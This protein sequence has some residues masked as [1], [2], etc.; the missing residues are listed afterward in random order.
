ML[1]TLRTDKQKEWVFIAGLMA[2]GVCDRE[3]EERVAVQRSDTAS[4]ASV[5]RLDH[6]TPEDERQCGTA[7]GESACE[8][9]ALG[10]MS[11][12][13]RSRPRS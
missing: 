11:E 9:V 13:C 2:A 6:R 7:L 3:L 1:Y 5:V 8:D 10:W 4:Q 12:A